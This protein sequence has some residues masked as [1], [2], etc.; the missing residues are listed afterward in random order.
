MGSFSPSGFCLTH[1]IFPMDYVRF[2]ADAKLWI[3]GTKTYCPVCDSLCEIIPGAYQLI[4]GRLNILLHPSISPE[5]LSAIRD[6]AQKLQRNE[7][8][9]EEADSEV[10]KISPDLAG[11]LRGL[12]QESVATIAAAI[13]SAVTAVALAK[14]AAPSTTIV[15][16]YY[17]GSP[18]L[19][20]A[21]SITKS[22]VLPEFGP[23]PNDK[24]GV[25][26]R[27]ERR[28]LS[29]NRAKK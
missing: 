26:N 6:V 8:S 21:T 24:P 4:G 29:K 3:E 19:S 5:A 20:H 13:I 7:I 16:N 1:G 17:G 2:S 25:M 15:N 23:V 28:K 22:P 9:K 14:M 12:K 18:A 10:S 11:L 27:K